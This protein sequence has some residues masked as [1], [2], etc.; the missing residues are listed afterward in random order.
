[1]DRETLLAELSYDP[2]T[3]LVFR[4]IRRGPAKARP[5]APLSTVGN[6][7]YI[8]A[9]VRS[10]PILLHRAIWLMVYG[11]EPEQIDHI[12]GDRTNNRLSNLRGITQQENLKNKRRVRL[13]NRSG[14]LGVSRQKKGGMYCARRLGRYLGAFATPEEASQAYWRARE[15]EKS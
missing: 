4:K 9:S 7:G 3:G 12:D 6:H 5:D 11:S 10:K 13:S 14:Y 1:M 8:V 2:E 15:E